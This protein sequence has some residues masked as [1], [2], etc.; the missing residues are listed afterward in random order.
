MPAMSHNTRGYLLTGDFLVIITPK[1][2][3]GL[4]AP[5]KHTG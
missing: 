1:S 2:A 4:M 5:R 3:G